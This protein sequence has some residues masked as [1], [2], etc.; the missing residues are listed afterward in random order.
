MHWNDVKMP[1]VDESTKNR[2]EISWN[3]GRIHEKDL[4]INSEE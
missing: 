3:I 1:V 4:K 2:F